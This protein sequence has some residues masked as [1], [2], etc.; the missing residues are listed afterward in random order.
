MRIKKTVEIEVSL[1]D[2]SDEE[3]SEEILKRGP[4]GAAHMLNK[5]MGILT[6]EVLEQLHWSIGEVG[7]RRFAD[8]IKSFSGQVE[9]VCAVKDDL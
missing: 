6:S 5:M 9:E 8:N 7:Y 3:L 4:L 2:F 1:A